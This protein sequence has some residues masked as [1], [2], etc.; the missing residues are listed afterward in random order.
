MYKKF[1]F[2]FH[3]Q[4]HILYNMKLVWTV[5]IFNLCTNVMQDVPDVF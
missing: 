1:D 4:V 3:F 2:F 5:T